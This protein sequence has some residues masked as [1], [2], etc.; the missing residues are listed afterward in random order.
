MTEDRIRPVGAAIRRLASLVG[1]ALFARMVL[2]TVLPLKALHVLG[3]EHYVSAIYFV[4]GS[5]AILVSLTLPALARRL[6][7]AHIFALG[8]LCLAA[9]LPALASSHAI[10]FAVGLAL[11]A[12]GVVMIEVTISLYALDTFR[13]DEF[14]RYEPVRMFLVGA[15]S[16]AG[17]W[18]GVYASTRF[19]AWTAYAISGAVV[20]ILAVTF[21]VSRPRLVQVSPLKRVPANPLS[22]LRS[23]ARQPRM[24]LAYVLASGR[25]ACWTTFYVYMPLFA[26]RLGFDELAAASLVSLAM[27]WILTAPVWGRVAARYGTRLVVMTGYGLCGA[28]MI[29]AGLT[30]ESPVLAL[31]LFVAAAFS[32]AILDGPG[33]VFFLRA[34]KPLQRAEMISV[35]TTYRDVGQT[36]PQL[37]FA[38]ILLFGDLGAVLVAAGLGALVLAWFGHYLPRRI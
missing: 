34:V 12:T 19:G 17:P 8:V 32:L 33:N 35:F 29:A 37:V 38:M 16:V 13:R 5:V 24:R 3:A 15:A 21:L 22:H 6:R 30:Q 4:T 7:R 18:L 1:L 26:V 27:I 28:F 11:Q 36:V 9:C 20:A 2:V 10:P 25:S 23:F 31:G 14:L